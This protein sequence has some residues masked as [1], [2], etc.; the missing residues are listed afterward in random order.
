MERDGVE[1]RVRF[2][3]PLGARQPIELFRKRLEESEQEIEGEV[4][5]RKRVFSNWEITAIF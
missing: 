2:S 1:N 3:V 4:M 5:V